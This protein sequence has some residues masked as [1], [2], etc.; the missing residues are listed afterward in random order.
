MKPAT[1]Y[2]LFMLLCIIITGILFIVFGETTVRRLRKEPSTREKLGF[3]FVGGRDII[4]VAMALSLPKKLMRKARS[5]K[6]DFMFADA[7]TLYQ[8]TTRYDRVMA[9]SFYYLFIWDA[10]MIFG[11]IFIKYV[12]G[13]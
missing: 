9:R 6:L 2:F 5:S 11:L 10:I 8:H 1:I 13:N 3:D 7:D 12:V 4:N